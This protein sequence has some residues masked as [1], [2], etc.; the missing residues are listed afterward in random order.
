MVAIAS[1]HAIILGL[2]MLVMGAMVSIKRAKTG[3]SILHGEDQSLATTIR[4][5]GNLAENAAM[6]MVL[7]ALAFFITNQTYRC[8]G[9]ARSATRLAC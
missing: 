8:V 5:H 2:M 7:L 3:I 4:R 1:I 6:A 9:L